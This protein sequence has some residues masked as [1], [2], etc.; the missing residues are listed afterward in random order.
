VLVR[1]TVADATLP[2]V[3]AIEVSRVPV[4]LTIKALEAV[5]VDVRLTRPP[6]AAAAAIPS[7][8]ALLIACANWVARPFKSS[9]NPT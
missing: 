6:A 2:V 1:V 5:I 9:S 4:S 7:I 3:V 8:P